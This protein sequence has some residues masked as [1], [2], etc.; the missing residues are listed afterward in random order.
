MIKRYYNLE[1][2]IQSGKVLIIY[3]PRRAGKTTL[4]NSFL[5]QTKLRYKLDSGDNIQ[6]QQ[7]LGSQNFNEIKEYAAGYDLI[8]I[9]EAQQVSNIG[10]GLKILVDQMPNLKIIATCSSSFDLAQKIGE[11]LT[12]RKKTIILFPFSQT[13]LLEKYN[14]YEMK[15]NLDEFLIFGSY[16]E[17]VTAKSRKEKIVLLNELANSYF[18][19]RCFCFRKNKGLKTTA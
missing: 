19:K 12:G 9:D 1:K 3:G 15:D 16:P 10:R 8:A 11:P 6:I 14:K 5:S 4:L 13:E 2:L 17:I 18:T 7:L